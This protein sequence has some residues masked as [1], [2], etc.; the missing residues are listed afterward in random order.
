MDFFWFPLFVWLGFFVVKWIFFWGLLPFPVS[1]GPGIQIKA[2]SN[3]TKCS[4]GRAYCPTLA[5]LTIS[6]S[7]N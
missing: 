1:V 4:E 2:C 6:R 3:R 5:A 7:R